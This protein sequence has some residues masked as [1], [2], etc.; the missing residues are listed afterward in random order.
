[1][2]ESVIERAALE[3]TREL[4]GRPLK[5]IGSSYR[6]PNLSLR[7]CSHTRNPAFDLFVM[8]A[9]AANLVNETEEIT[10]YSLSFVARRTSAGRELN[11]W[12]GLDT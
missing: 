4:R 12:K 5:F 3:Y 11:L 8:V 1:M 10:E 9:D 7:S 6:A 2:P